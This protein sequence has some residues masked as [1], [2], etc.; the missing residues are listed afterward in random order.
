MIRKAVSVLL[1]ISFVVSSLVGCQVQGT[2]GEADQKQETGTEDQA[3]EK[4]KTDAVVSEEG[5]ESQNQPEEDKLS[6]IHI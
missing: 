4:G 5:E 1:I 2:S 6:L 3:G